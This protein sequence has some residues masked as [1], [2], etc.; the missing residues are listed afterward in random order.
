M[1]TIKLEID[2]D[3]KI[4]SVTEDIDGERISL[5]LDKMVS[6]VTGDLGDLYLKL[7]VPHEDIMMELHAK[8]SSMMKKGATFDIMP[9]G[10]GQLLI[11]VKGV[12]KVDAYS[13]VAERIKSSKGPIYV[14]GLYSGEW[15]ST[16]GEI[17][18]YDHKKQISKIVAQLL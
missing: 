1:P 4:S 10:D 7:L 16:G 12:F 15:P 9:I 13:H 5:P 18:E 14:V 11:R 17:A 6:F 8:K 2:F 3:S